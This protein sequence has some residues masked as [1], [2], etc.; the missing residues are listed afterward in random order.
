MNRNRGWKQYIV[1]M[2]LNFFFSLSLPLLL[3]ISFSFPI[4][5]RIFLLLPFSLHIYGFFLLVLLE[6]ISYNIKIQ[7]SKLWFVKHIGCIV[8]WQGAFSVVR[9]QAL[10]IKVCIRYYLWLF[11]QN[12]PIIIISAITNI[13]FVLKL[14]IIYYRRM[15]LWRRWNWCLF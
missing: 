7:T 8:Q 2:K 10:L 15:F 14:L 3:R 9:E 1:L 4:L 11:H 13:Q 5:L 6:I 12:N